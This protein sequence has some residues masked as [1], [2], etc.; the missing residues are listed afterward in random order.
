MSQAT[1]L[2]SRNPFP[3]GDP[4]R[5]AIWEMLVARDITAFV[6]A[7]WTLVKDD[8]VENEFYGIDGRRTANPDHWTMGF[9]D[10][11]TYRDEWLRQAQASQATEFAE[12]LTEAIF[13]NTVLRD[14]E[15]SGDRAIAH[16]KFDG[17]IAL[18]DGGFD[19]MLWQTVYHCKRVDG[20]WKISGFV[21]YL[22]N[23]MG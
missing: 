2:S 9:P 5:A 23:P 17:T 21:G 20:R 18:K 10:L 15:I 19:R 4:D 22:P 13:R 3:E 1:G 14:I 7:D 11:A 8:F 16:K 12:D 6:N